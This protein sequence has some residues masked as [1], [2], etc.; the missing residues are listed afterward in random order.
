MSKKIKRLKGIV[1]FFNPTRAWGFIVADDG[2]NFF[3]HS[4]SVDRE[5]IPPLFRRDVLA[6]GEIV[7]FTSNVSDKGSGWEATEIE[8]IEAKILKN[9]PPRDEGGL[10][11]KP[12]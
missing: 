8:V 6:P 7:E 3:V 11:W 9:I 10:R 1:K 2:R 4:R 12:Y 5:P